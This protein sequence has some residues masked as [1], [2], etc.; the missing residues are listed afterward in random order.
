MSDAVT[1]KSGKVKFPTST[2]VTEIRNWT[3]NRP[4]ETPDATSMSSGGNREKKAG[5]RDW[6]GTFETIK[7]VDL[8]GQEAVGTLMVDGSGATASTPQFSGTMLISDA[9]V[10]VPYDDIVAYKHTFEGSG[11]CTAATT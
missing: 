10:E 6:S 3:L 1:G 5:I 4:M 7:F 2:E 9:P 8:A 11:P